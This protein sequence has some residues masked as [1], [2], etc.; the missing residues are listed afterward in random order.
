MIKEVLIPFIIELEITSKILK[1]LLITISL[2]ILSF[3]FLKN[4][5]I[6]ILFIKHIK[7][8]YNPNL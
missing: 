5:Q 1:L 3:L 7:Y 4:I 8:R 6:I 2:S